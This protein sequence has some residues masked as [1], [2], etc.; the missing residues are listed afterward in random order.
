MALPNA[1]RVLRRHFGKGASTLFAALELSTGL[2]MQGIIGAGAPG[3]TERFLDFFDGHAV[4]LI[5]RLVILVVVSLKGKQLVSVA[6]PDHGNVNAP[7]HP[8]F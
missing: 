4:G 1:I 2:V 3:A 6:L 5:V 7:F 8:G